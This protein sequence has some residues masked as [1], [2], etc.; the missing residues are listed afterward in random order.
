MPDDDV[1]DQQDPST[2]PDA[3]GAEPDTQPDPTPE[4]TEPKVFDE[5]YVQDLRSE[6]AKYR[7]RAQEAEAKVKEHD[8]AQMSELEKAQTQATESQKEIEGLRNL[9]SAERTRNAVTLEATNMKFQD[10]ADALAMID[11]SELNIDDETGKPTTKSVQG[12][13]NRLVK[14]KPYLVG[15]VSEP[16]PGTADGGATG[17][18]GDLTRDQK[19]AQYEKDLQERYGSVPMPSA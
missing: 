13:L 9:L 15:Q 3:L 8:E 2:E 17:T 12:A 6:S 14:D 10:P 1:K 19:I 4:V 11:V 7:R 16:D 18:A 5:K